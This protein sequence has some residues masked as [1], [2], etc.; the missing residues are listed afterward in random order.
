MSIMPETDT[1]R[2]V[3]FKTVL[4]ECQ[5]TSAP[6]KLKDNTVVKNIILSEQDDCLKIDAL[7]V[8]KVDLARQIPRCH[9]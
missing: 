3:H 8:A 7:P 5:K 2:P 9:Q 6:V 1:D 4:F